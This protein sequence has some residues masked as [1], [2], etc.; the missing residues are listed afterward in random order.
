MNNM[1]KIIFIIIFVVN[2]A[3]AS[4]LAWWL[5]V[6]FKVEGTSI[7]GIPIENIDPSWK[8]ANILSRDKI[9]KKALDSDPY[10]P[11]TEYNYRFII[12]KDINNDGSAEKI[13]TG[14]YE[15]KDGNK[16]RFIL[17]LETV[18]KSWQKAFLKK[19]GE[20]SGFSILN[21]TKEGVV[22]WTFCMECGM[23]GYIKWDG[24]KYYIQWRDEEG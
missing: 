6:N 12:E 10:D 7:E 24:E 2:T 14:V 22:F 15:T 3:S 1:K 17:I 20:T 19:G 21:E 23:A 16:G 5:T 8:Y 4:Q 13:L 18:K 11:M 9:P